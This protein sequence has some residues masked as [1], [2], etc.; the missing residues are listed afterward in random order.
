MINETS[1]KNLEKYLEL[2]DAATENV[3]KLKKTID[4]VCETQSI[5][6]EHMK[7]QNSR[8]ETLEA[9]I[10]SSKTEDHA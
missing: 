9:H 5:I 2:F 3:S 10:M 6:I 4:A 8:I 1:D 7:T